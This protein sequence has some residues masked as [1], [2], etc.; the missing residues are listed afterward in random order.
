MGREENGGGVEK[1]DEGFLRW[2]G[3]I[4]R[5][6]KG[7][8]DGRVYNG[9]SIRGGFDRANNPFKRGLIVNKQEDVTGMNGGDL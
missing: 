3:H 4:E 8:I 2:F 1:I 5:M 7:R 9:K 6:E